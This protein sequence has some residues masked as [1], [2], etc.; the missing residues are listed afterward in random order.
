[1]LSD[2]RFV[3]VESVVDVAMFGIVI[4]SK[5]QKLLVKRFKFNNKLT[6][7]FEVVKTSPDWS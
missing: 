2:S 3:N 6:S 4:R 1:L 7:P 5:M